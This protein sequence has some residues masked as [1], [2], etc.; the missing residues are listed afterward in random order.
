MQ[1]VGNLLTRI[2]KCC[3]PV[4]GDEIIG[5]ISSGRGVSIHRIN[6]N[7]ILNIDENLTNRLVDVDWGQQS[8]S[9]YNLGLWVTAYHRSGLLH[10]IIEMLKA[11][12]V[13]VLKVNMET[14]Q[15]HVTR[16]QFRLEISAA[17]RPEQL[18]SRLSSIQNVFGVRR[19]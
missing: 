12:N 3:Q 14:D 1:G 2:A 10:E 16:L 13:D 7:N 15:E 8:R 6:C 17:L 5:F 18:I 9:S 19:D 11:A 4:P